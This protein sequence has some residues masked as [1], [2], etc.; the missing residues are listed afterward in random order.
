MP[1]F[2]KSRWRLELG[3]DVELNV[4]WF[5]LFLEILMSGSSSTSF[6]FGSDFLFSRI[7]ILGKDVVR[8]IGGLFEVSSVSFSSEWSEFDNSTSA[9]DFISL[10][11]FFSSS[12]LLSHHTSCFCLN[13]FGDSEAFSHLKIDSVSFSDCARPRLCNSLLSGFF[14]SKSLAM[15]FED[16]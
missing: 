12:S 9:F 11:S 14:I 2:L 13:F 3:L 15:Y 4:T 16:W 10:N 6:I 5:E 8:F 1:C 7:L